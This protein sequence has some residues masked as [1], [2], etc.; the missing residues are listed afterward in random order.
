MTSP[1]QYAAVADQL[2][3]ATDKAAELWAQGAKALA[4]QAEALSKMTAGDPAT[5][6]Q[7]YFDLLQ[8]AVEV[9]TELASQW[10]DAVR[11]MSEAFGS[12]VSTLTGITQQSMGPVGDVITVQ[13]DSA[14]RVLDAAA[15]SAGQ[16]VDTAADSA[17]QAVDTA[18]D[19][20]N[21]AVDAAAICKSGGRHCGPVGAPDGRRRDR[22]GEHDR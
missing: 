15:D 7:R 18:A 16:A 9:N 21:Q 1:E 13:A 6:V 2:R 4:Q 20:A 5:G 14:G 19:S 22:G 11:S 8:Q 3:S 10:A 17:G 12:Q